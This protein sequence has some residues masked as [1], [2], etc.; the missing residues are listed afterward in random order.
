M[1]G[2]KNGTKDQNMAP[3]ARAD[4]LLC[5]AVAY[6]NAEVEGHLLPDKFSGEKEAVDSMMKV[7]WFEAKH[8]MSEQ[9]PAPDEAYLHPVDIDSGEPGIVTSKSKQPEILR[10]KVPL[11]QVVYHKRAPRQAPAV[12]I[13][14]PC[15]VEDAHTE[16]TKAEK[17][18][19]AC[20][21]RR[22]RREL[23]AEQR[24]IDK[25]NESEE[26]KRK[27]SEETPEEREERLQEQRAK[28][29]GEEA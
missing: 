27:R 19:V 2:Q 9:I 12:K 22:A 23:K 6:R 8:S 21:Q 13:D 11:P 7:L 26:K 1:Q 24:S 3:H 20:S 5:C 4:R 29:R 18:N 17:K 10:R 16:A 14:P 28:T 15:S 25:L